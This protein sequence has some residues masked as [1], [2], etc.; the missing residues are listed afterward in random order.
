MPLSPL[1]L[2]P[3]T[4]SQSNYLAIIRQLQEQIAT[5]I[6]QVEGGGTEEAI[7]SIE[8]ARL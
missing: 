3:Y 7:V 5:L 2:L 6:V 1:P 4:M 8:V